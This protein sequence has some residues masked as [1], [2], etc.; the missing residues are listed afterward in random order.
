[1]RCNSTLI[2][3]SNNLNITLQV[4]VHISYHVSNTVILYFQVIQNKNDTQNN[5]NSQL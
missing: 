3:F 4:F 1:M 2:S 5:E